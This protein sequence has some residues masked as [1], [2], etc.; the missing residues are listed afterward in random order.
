MVEVVEV[1]GATDVVLTEV[2]MGVGTTDEATLVATLRM[3]ATAL[4]ATEATG[5]TTALLA[6]ETTEDTAVLAAA[7]ARTTSE[8]TAEPPRMLLATDVR[9]K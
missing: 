8:Q 5:L 3:E 7:V 4:V 9:L 1:V 6:T 2:A